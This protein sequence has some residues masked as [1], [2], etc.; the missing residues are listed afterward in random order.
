MTGETHVLRPRC[1]VGRVPTADLRVEDTRTSGE[2]AVL[3]HNGVR[4]EVRDLGSTNGT[5]V[6][7]HRLQKGERMVLGAGAILMFGGKEVTYE[8]ADDTAP[9]P[10]ARNLRTG[11]I[12]RATARI[13]A[14]PSI[15]NAAVTIFERLDGQWIVESQSSEQ[16]IADRGVVNVDGD[17]WSLEL[18]DA[19][20]I[21]IETSRFG[22]Y[23][24]AS[25]L[26]FTT[27][28][29]DEQVQL[30]LLHE[31]GEIALGQR[32]YHL[33]LLVLAKAFLADEHLAPEERGWVERDK[34]CRDLGIDAGKLNVD[35]YRA[36]KQ[37]MAAGVLG[38]P[39][40]VTR[41]LDTGH[42]RL[43][44]QAVEIV[45]AARPGEAT[46]PSEPPPPSSKG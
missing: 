16:P 34:V 39:N 44:V 4:W 21:T 18:P 11:E 19:S 40:L 17:L 24:E 35:I 7:R 33:P 27:R 46:P 42:M 1:L 5:W 45:K 37:L 43:G 41:R 12:V 8:L 32:Q 23:L 13:L 30:A 31:G 2:H 6:N 3:H 10:S 14:L 25:K 36:R 15:D 26:R 28:H 29:N 20:A 38:A 22:P 9:S